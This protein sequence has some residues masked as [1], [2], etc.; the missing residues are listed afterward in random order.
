MIRRVLIAVCLG[1]F[2]TSDP[3][4]AHKLEAAYSFHPGWR[5]QVE[6]WYEGGDPAAGARIRV[7]R[8]GGRLVVEDRLNKDGIFV[9]VFPEVDTLEVSI[10][11]VG[12]RANVTIPAEKFKKN[13]LGICLSCWTPGSPPFLPAALLVPVPSEEGKIASYAPRADRRSGF[14]LGSTLAGAG[15]LLA[16]AILFKWLSMRKSAT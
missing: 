4:Y 16:V 3:A 1:L 13:V 8:S 14:P 6:G 7:T 9:F 5:I 2:L 11:Q 10:T 15:A 12:H